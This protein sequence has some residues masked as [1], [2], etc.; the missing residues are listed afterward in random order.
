MII[1]FIFLIKYNKIN[2]VKAKKYHV[3]GNPTD[4][5][6]GSCSKFLGV[7]DFFMT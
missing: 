6:F 7:S 1:I 2:L 4:P 5:T 3:I